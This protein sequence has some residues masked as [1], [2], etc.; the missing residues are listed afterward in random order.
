MFFAWFRRCAVGTILVA[1]GCIPSAPPKEAD[2]KPNVDAVSAAG[3]AAETPAATEA[4]LVAEWSALSGNR[5][6]ARQTGRH[7]E[8]A[9]M[10]TN[11][12]PEAL[13]PIID[14]MGKPD[15]APQV[16]VFAVESMSMF[17]QPAHI[18]K[19]GAILDSKNDTTARAC[20]ASLLGTIREPKALEYLRGAA[21][22]PDRRIRFS[23]QLGLASQGDKGMRDQVAAM[24][25]QAEASPEEKTQIVL[26]VLKDA[27]PTDLPLLADALLM[28]T[29]DSVLKGMIVTSLGRIGDGSVVDSLT[30]SKAIVN[31]LAY[32]ET[33]D[34][35]LA[36]I[37]ERVA[38]PT[39]ISTQAAP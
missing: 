13:F 21:N 10:L 3:G 39:Q 19:L 2:D 31:E 30:K 34:A 29:M 26:L 15:T 25:A 8:I 9:Y 17:T 11:M 16:R 35:A 4:R 37:A 23:A 18:E 14:I 27:G 38:L 32:S 5:D 12:R 24:F 33:V 22:D 20:A 36:V 6:T 1:C 7:K 28:P